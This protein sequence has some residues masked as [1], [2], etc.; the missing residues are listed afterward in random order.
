MNSLI[1]MYMAMKQQ[2]EQKQVIRKQRQAPRVL[3]GG[4]ELYRLQR[5]KAGDQ[6]DVQA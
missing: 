1:Y 5:A 6:G 2:E 3:A 4:C